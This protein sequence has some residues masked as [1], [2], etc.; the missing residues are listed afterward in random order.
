M[1][2][3]SSGSGCR[4]AAGAASCSQLP[5]HSVVMWPQGS[6]RGAA[7]WALAAASFACFK[8]E[9]STAFLQVASVPVTRPMTPARVMA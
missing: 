6:S 2:G 5:L 4:G 1:V 9:Y 7:S 3:S 8:S